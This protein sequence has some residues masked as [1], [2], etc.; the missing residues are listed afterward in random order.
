MTDPELRL[1][2]IYEEHRHDGFL[3]AFLPKSFTLDQAANA[4]KA[5][6]VRPH[7]IVE[8]TDWRTTDDGVAV[9]FV[10]LPETN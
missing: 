6:D 8:V 3:V 7:K 9:A 4:L 10:P 5:M 2:I 1:F